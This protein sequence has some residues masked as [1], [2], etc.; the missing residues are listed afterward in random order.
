MTLGDAYWTESIRPR[1]CEEGILIFVCVSVSRV[2]SRGTSMPPLSLGQSIS[3]LS[4]LVGTAFGVTLTLCV[5]HTN[6]TPSAAGTLARELADARRTVRVL[7]AQL[8]HGGGT[9]EA[10]VEADVERRLAA[11]A[12]QQWTETPD[13]RRLHDALSRIANA[14]GEV[15]VAIANDVMMCTNRKTCWWNGGNV[16]ETFLKSVSRLRLTNVLVI[17]L[18]DATES[19]CR[20]F[21]FEPAWSAN[22]LRLELPVPTAQ[23]GSRGANMIST[24]KYGLLRQALLMGFSIL[25]VDLDLVWLKDPF[26]HLHRDADVEAST[27]GFTAGWAGGQIG[28]VHEPK[29]G[30]GAGGLYVQHFTLNVGCAFFRPTPR[31][32]DL[33]RRVAT[34]LAMASA[35]DQQVFNQ[36]AFMLS[37]GAYNGSKVAVRVMDYMQWVNSKVFFFSERRAFF[38]GKPTPPEKLPVMVHMNYHPDKHKRMLCVW[39]RYVEARHDACDGFPPGGT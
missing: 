38:P 31:A 29:M 25:V 16:L 3:L 28:S 20:G 22:S 11:P 14:R 9:P 17:T 27:D 26:N 33:L 34:R 2:R 18:D 6:G 36:E 21:A 5:L 8:S 12:A 1:E 30:W 39:A 19:F 4:A 23:Q 35:W 37:H 24:L 15:M 32:I 13:N 7:R 10:T